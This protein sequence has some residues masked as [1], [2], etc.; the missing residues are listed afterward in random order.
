VCASFFKEKTPLGAV[1]LSQRMAASPT[2]HNSVYALRELLEI[3]KSHRDVEPIQYMFSLWRNLLVNGPQTGIAIGKNCDR[4]GFVDSAL[5]QRKTDR[6][7]RLGTSVA[8]ESKAG[9]MP[10]AIQR[11]AGNDLKVS[12]RS[13]VSISDVPT[14]EADYQFFAG[15]VRSSSSEDFRRLLKPPAHLHRPVAHGAGSRL[16]R[17]REKLAEEISDLSKRHQS[18]HLGRNIPQLGR[19]GTLVREQR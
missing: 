15:P 19:D 8:H 1:D 18:S 3:R 2:I 12:F 11:L 13:L 9:G 16:R 6:A 17:Q 5:P 4:R 10:V 7:D 14:I